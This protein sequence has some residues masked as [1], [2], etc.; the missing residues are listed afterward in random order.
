M[1]SLPSRQDR[2]GQVQVGPGS[3]CRGHSAQLTAHVC[4][5]LHTLRP[6]THPQRRVGPSRLPWVARWARRPEHPAPL[7]V[8]PALRW[9]LAVTPY[10]HMVILTLKRYVFFLLSY[11]A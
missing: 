6:D 9:K 3:G 10:F 4:G 5:A 11:L 2:H 8:W 7:G 1:R